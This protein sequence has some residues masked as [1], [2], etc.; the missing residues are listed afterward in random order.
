MKMIIA[1]VHCDDAAHISDCLSQKGYGTTC[2]RS[3]GSFLQQENRTL[4]IGV[5]D[6]KV[7]EVTSII[8]SAVHWR[9]AEVTGKN[10]QNS[11]M[12]AED[13]SVTVAG[14]TLFVLDVDQ[15]LRV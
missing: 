13:A 5:A 15:F 2:M 8:R 7:K 4:L 11:M 1:I 10:P 3:Q 9:S 14:A 12:V 6:E